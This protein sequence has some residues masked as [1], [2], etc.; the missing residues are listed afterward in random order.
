MAVFRNVKRSQFACEPTVVSFWYSPS[1]ILLA[2][3]KTRLV[4]SWGSYY[5]ERENR[6]RQ[7][8]HLMGVP[9]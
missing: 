9:S 5:F 8:Y 6:I 4:L 2:N 1:R 3:S 7:Q